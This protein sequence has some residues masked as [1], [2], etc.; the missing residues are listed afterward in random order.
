MRYVGDRGD[1]DIGGEDFDK[2]RNDLGEPSSLGDIIPDCC[3]F[4]DNGVDL[5]DLESAPDNGDPGGDFPPDVIEL[6]AD[7]RRSDP[8]E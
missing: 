1:G 6:A 4:G 3:D 7:F 8:E 2:L 5:G